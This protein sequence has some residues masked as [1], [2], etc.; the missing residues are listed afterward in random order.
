MYVNETILMKEKERSRIRAVQ[1][2]S[3]RGF[4]G[5][6]SMDRIPN[7]RIK[8]LCGV[9]KGIDERIEEGILLWF[10]HVERIE[11]DKLSVIL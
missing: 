2:D 6:R 9:M 4:L 7:K 5:S 1:T 3:L 8:E 11:N 10:G